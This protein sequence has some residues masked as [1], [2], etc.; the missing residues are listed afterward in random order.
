MFV[1]VILGISGFIQ[2]FLATTVLKAMFL[3]FFGYSVVLIPLYIQK[4]MRIPTSKQ[5]IFHYIDR[6]AAFY[7]LIRF[8]SNFVSSFFKAYAFYLC[9]QLDVNTAI[10][11]FL[12]NT[13]I[14]FLIIGGRVFFNEQLSNTTY[15]GIF[16]VVLSL[17]GLCV[18]N[19]IVTDSSVSIA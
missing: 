10:V 14:A 3:R 8:I 12:L 4:F 18:L 6:D 2:G 19:N 17:F 5:D 7:I 9:L 11:T 16:L 1:G 15:F 13:S